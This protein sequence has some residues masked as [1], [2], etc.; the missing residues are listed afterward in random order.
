MLDVCRGPIAS[1][2]PGENYSQTN[3][4]HTH[5]H[6]HT[7]TQ[8]VPRTPPGSAV[9]YV[10][11]RLGSGMGGSG[12]RKQPNK[13]KHCCILGPLMKR[14]LASLSQGSLNYSIRALPCNFDQMSIYISGGFSSEER[15]EGPP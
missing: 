3:D 6:T 7:H 4:E 13:S 10:W 9:P 1:L 15:E 8:R 11:K 5:T 12:E 2:V 14:V